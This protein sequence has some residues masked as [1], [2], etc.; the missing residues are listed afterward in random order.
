[1]GR[2]CRSHASSNGRK[3]APPRDWPSW[4]SAVLLSN[5]CAACVPGRQR[6]E[7]SFGF[8]VRRP[9]SALGFLDEA[10]DNGAQ[11]V[12]LRKSPNPKILKRCRVTALRNPKVL[13]F[14][15]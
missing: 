9:G 8:G 10:L 6:R 14:D 5:T 7:E 2:K 13:V 4:K 1:M 3:A 15:L 12:G 11:V